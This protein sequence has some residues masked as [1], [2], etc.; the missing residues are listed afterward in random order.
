MPNETLPPEP[1]EVVDLDHGLPGDP[2]VEP[3]DEPDM[4]TEINDEEDEEDDD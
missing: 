3:D 4:P 2:E 1:G